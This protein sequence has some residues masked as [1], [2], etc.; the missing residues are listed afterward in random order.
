MNQFSVIS[1]QTITF[2]NFSDY[3]SN[4]LPQLSESVYPPG[5]TSAQAR[6]VFCLWNAAL[7]ANL[8]FFMFQGGAVVKKVS[9]ITV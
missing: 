4:K 6:I 8:T 2:K 5:G 1:I 3:C 9:V 7:L